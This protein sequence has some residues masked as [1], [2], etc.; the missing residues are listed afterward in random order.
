MAFGTI[1]ALAAPAIA[2]L[3]S[4][5]KK[6]SGGQNVFDPAQAIEQA[7]M[8]VPEVTESE[9]EAIRQ[10]IAR[11]FAPQQGLLSQAI[12][13][14]PGL[15]QSGVSLLPK[16][17]L[18]AAEA[19]ETAGQLGSLEAQ[20]RQNLFSAIQNSLGLSQQ[21]FL[22]GQAQEQSRLAERTGQRYSLQNLLKALPISLATAGAGGAL[23]RASGGNT[24][25]SDEIK[26]LRT[27]GILRS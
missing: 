19:T 14:R 11:S 6:G 25:E 26:A 7:K 2:G 3:L 4:R 5:K 8:A 24:K 13:M 21:R 20:R 16:A 17:N 9:R 10:S 18:Q 1:A 27:L 22:T 15:R 12:G 23:S